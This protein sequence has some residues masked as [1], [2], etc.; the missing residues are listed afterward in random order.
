MDTL[1]D[2]CPIAQQA[3]KDAGCCVPTPVIEDHVP[4]LMT[5]AFTMGSDSNSRNRWGWATIRGRK[6]REKE[7]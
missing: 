2:E 6:T 7:K 1:T 3:A 4:V 5:M